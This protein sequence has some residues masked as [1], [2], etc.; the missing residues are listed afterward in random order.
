MAMAMAMAMAS[1]ASGLEP[2]AHYDVVRKA[3]WTANH[4]SPPVKYQ[5]PPSAVHFFSSTAVFDR[6]Y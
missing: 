3:L 2:S 4:N 1:D 6:R 5:P